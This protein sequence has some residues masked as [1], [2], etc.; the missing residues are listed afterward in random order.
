MSRPCSHSSRI[1]HSNRRL[2]SIPPRCP[3]NPRC[4]TT[5][6]KI[7]QRSG[8]PDVG[9]LGHHCKNLSITTGVIQIYSPGTPL[10]PHRQCLE[11]GRCTCTRR[12]AHSCCD[13]KAYSGDGRP[14]PWKWR[15]EG[16]ATVSPLSVGFPLSTFISFLHLR[17]NMHL[18]VN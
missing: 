10:H 16:I 8:S 2:A 6:H 17:D 7:P 14:G 11:G 1:L 3:G 4:G 9:F 18:F 15:R 5:R 13:D 12:P